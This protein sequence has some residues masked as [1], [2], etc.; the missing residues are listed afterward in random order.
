VRI[1]PG[2]VSLPDFNTRAFHGCTFWIQNP[3]HHVQQVRITV[4]SA[5]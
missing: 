2:G 5:S 4:R 3:S 1:T